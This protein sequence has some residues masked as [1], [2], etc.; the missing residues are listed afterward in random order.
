MKMLSVSH[1]HSWPKSG[2]IETEAHTFSELL[3]SWDDRLFCPYTGRGL[4]PYVPGLLPHGKCGV[5]ALAGTR[6]EAEAV[7]QEAGAVVETV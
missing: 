2:M 3:D 5:V 7:Y 4:V 1:A 6:E